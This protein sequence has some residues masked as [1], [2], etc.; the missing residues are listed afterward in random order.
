METK[1][2]ILDKQGTKAILGNREYKK[3][4]YCIEG[5]GNEP[6][7]FRGIKEQLPDTVK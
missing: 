5:T 2:N 4:P 6:I 3:M 1:V 7:K